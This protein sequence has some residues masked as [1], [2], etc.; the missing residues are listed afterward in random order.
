MFI[1]EVFISQKS[2]K[3]KKGD[4]SIFFYAFLKFG[5]GIS[6]KIDLPMVFL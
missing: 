2:G 6:L 4:G 5:L 1:I 3:Y